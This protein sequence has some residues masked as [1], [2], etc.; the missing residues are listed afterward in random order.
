MADSI[1]AALW[2]ALAGAAAIAT[3]LGALQYRV[4]IPA[5]APTSIL[6]HISVAS[7][8]TGAVVALVVEPLSGPLLMFEGKTGVLTQVPAS[9]GRAYR[10]PNR[11]LVMVGLGNMLLLAPVL[12]LILRSRQRRAAEPSGATPA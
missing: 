8:A 5:N 10:A 4:G 3:L 2:R 6:Q 12:Y 9:E 1:P 7:Q 11:T